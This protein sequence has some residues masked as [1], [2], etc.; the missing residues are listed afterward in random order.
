M[1]RIIVEDYCPICEESYPPHMF[2]RCSR[3]KRSYCL[4]CIIVDEKGE[5]LCLNCARRRV[6]PPFRPGSKYAPLSIY[7][8]RRSKYTSKVTL[9]FSSIEEIIGDVLPPSAYKSKGWWSNVRNRSPSESW[10]TAGWKVES[11]NL[12]KEE[13][14]FVKEELKCKEKG[15]FNS[16]FRNRSRKS[17]RRLVEKRKKK[18][19]QPSRTK[20][21][22]AL[23]RL[24]NLKEKRK[25]TPKYR[26]LKPKSPYE[27]R[28]YKQS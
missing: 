6:T 11:V 25:S 28:L 27:K 21:A 10:L 13:V 9:Q 26:G 24:Q 7:L 22:K 12:E 20:L 1:R 4:N 18:K 14:T 17:I 16:I 23:A 2:R 8:A 19:I 15:S 3:C 5:F